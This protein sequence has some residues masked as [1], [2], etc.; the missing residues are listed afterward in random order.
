MKTHIEEVK[1][2][3]PALKRAKGEFIVKYLGV[4]YDD[5]RKEVW[6]IREFVDG[7]DLEAL[8]KNPSLCPALRSPEKR[9]NLAVGICKGMAYLHNLRTPFLHGDF[10]PSDV[11]VPAKD[12]QPKITNFGICDF[13]SFFVENAQRE[14]EYMEFL[15]ACQAPEVLV[16]GKERA[17]RATLI[18]CNFHYFGAK[19]QICFLNFFFILF[20]FFFSFFFAFFLNNFKFFNFI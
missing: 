6:V 5:F 11:L 10:K 13:K 1:K 12:L 18:D 4:S 20:E 15:N 3:M 14:D 9:I 16:G 8:M 17:K 2:L 19:I 7:A